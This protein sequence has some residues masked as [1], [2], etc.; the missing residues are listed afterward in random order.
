M[1]VHP[2]TQAR[3]I[4]VAGLMNSNLHSEQVLE[5][6]KDV[7]GIAGKTHAAAHKVYQRAQWAKHWYDEMWTSS[8]PESFWRASVLFLQV[9]DG[10]VTLLKPNFEASEVYQFALAER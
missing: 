2:A 1:S 8:D 7:P 3:A 5:R 10:R 6:F 4:F 9:T